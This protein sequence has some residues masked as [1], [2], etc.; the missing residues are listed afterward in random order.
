MACHV[1]VGGIVD[2][3][4][5]CSSSAG[6]FSGNSSLDMVVKEMIERRLKKRSAPNDRVTVRSSIN[7]DHRLQ[8]GSTMQCWPI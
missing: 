6:D 7:R 4:A 1:V 5:T 8:L 2:A 3:S